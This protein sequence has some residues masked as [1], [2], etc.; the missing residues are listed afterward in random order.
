MLQTFVAK[1]GIARSAS[2]CTVLRDIV[3]ISAH[4]GERFAKPLAA[5][6]TVLKCGAQIG[7][8]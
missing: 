2:M 1:I 7:Q 5:R 8:T 4:I 3:K 6:L